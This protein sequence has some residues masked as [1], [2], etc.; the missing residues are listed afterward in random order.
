MAQSGHTCRAGRCLLS[1]AKRTSSK[2]GV[3]SAYDPQRKLLRVLGAR[4]RRMSIT[5]TK[6]DPSDK[7]QFWGCR[8]PAYN[9][10]HNG[11]RKRLINVAI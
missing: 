4:R 2:D 11:Y 10:D 1:G 8:G 3:M 7:R 5:V 6:L 9:R